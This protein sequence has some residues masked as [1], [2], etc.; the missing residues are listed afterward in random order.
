MKVPANGG[1][2]LSVLDGWWCEG[3]QQDN[4][5][6]IG[7]GEDYDDQTYQDDV[8]S[9][10]LY[11]LLENEIVPTFYERS[12]DDIPRE[13]TRIMKNSMRTVNAEFNTNRMVEEYTERFYMPCVENAERLSGNDFALAKE[14]AGWRRQMKDGWKK[15]KVVAVEAPPV[16]AQPMGSS[17]TVQATLQL[18]DIPA[19]EIL[20]E[21]YHGLLNS[22]GEI[23]NGE[24]STL[25]PTESA[26][27]GTV[28]YAGDIACRRAGRR[29]FTV[30]AVPRK[31]GFPLD[32]FETGLISWWNDPA[33]GTAAGST[34]HSGVTVHRA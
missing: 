5:W 1:I 23:V 22:D 11:D 19:E 12:S 8:E 17:L 4:G 33:S 34:D 7:A 18:G 13:W 3:Y 26:N 10:A 9:T 30:R 25:F 6:A 29:G 24:A 31:D 15:V 28:V 16:A 27:D 2:N 20:V 14:L 32:R 21:V